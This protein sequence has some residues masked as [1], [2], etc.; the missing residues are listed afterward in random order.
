MHSE[1]STCSGDEQVKPFPL[2]CN[3]GFIVLSLQLILNFSDVIV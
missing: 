1:G 3:E 2:V